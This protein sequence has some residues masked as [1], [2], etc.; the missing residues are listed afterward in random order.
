MTPSRHIRPLSSLLALFLLLAL[1]L[2]SSPAS[3]QIPDALLRSCPSVGN[4]G[5]P[6][7]LCTYGTAA[8]PHR[9][10]GDVLQ[11]HE[12]V[13]YPFDPPAFFRIGDSNLS[14]SMRSATVTFFYRVDTNNGQILETEFSGQ[15][16]FPNGAVG[17]KPEFSIRILDSNGASIDTVCLE[18]VY[19]G[20][21][22]PLWTSR[23]SSIIN[24]SLSRFLCFDLRPLHGRTVQIRFNSTCPSPYM[25]N[26][27]AKFSL[28]CINI[29]DIIHIYNCATARSSVAPRGFR[30][31]WSLSSDT[32]TILT[33][34][35]VFSDGGSRYLTELRCKLRFDSPTHQNT[36][37]VKNLYYTPYPA[38]EQAGY[39]FHRAPF[40][41]DT[42]GLLTS[43]TCLIQFRLRD[44]TMIRVL[45][46]TG[47]HYIHNSPLFQTQYRL[48]S[49]CDTLLLP[50]TTTRF[51]LPAG[52]HILYRDITT[53]T[54]TFTYSYNLQIDTFPCAYMDDLIR[55]CPETIDTCSIRYLCYTYGYH[56]H[57]NIIDS[58]PSGGWRQRSVNYFYPTYFYPY[59]HI[60]P[61]YGIYSYHH[62]HRNIDSPGP[63]SNTLGQ[64]STAPW[65]FQSS[66]LLGYETSDIRSNNQ[67]LFFRYHAD[68][69]QSSLLML[70]Y[71]LVM[72]HLA[73]DPTEFY[74]NTPWYQWLNSHGGVPLDSL[75]S[76][77]SKIRPRFLFHLLDSLGAE[78]SPE[79]YTLDI[80]VDTS[81]QWNIGKD[82]TF[83]WKDWTSFGIGLQRLHGRTFTVHI[84][85]DYTYSVFRFFDNPYWLYTSR[86]INYAYLHFQCLPGSIHA[87]HCRDT[88]HYT[89]PL[90]FNYQWFPDRHPDSI[91]ATSQTFVTTSD[92]IFY[93]RLTDHRDTT[94]TLILPAIPSPPQHPVA[95]LSLDTLQILD[96]CTYLLRLNNRSVIAT[97]HRPDSITTVP[98]NDIQCWLD[99]TLLIYPDTS[100]S[101]LKSSFYASPGQHTLT[102]VA[103]ITGTSCTDTLRRPLLLQD[104]CHCYDTIFDTIVQNQL[105]YQWHGITFTLDSFT[106][107]TQASHSQNSPNSPLSL[108]TSLFIPGTRPQCDSLISYHLTLYLNT[109]DSAILVLCPAAIPYHINDTLLLSS[110][111][112]FTLRG[113]HGQDSLVSY[114][115][116][117]L[118][119][120]DT[121]IVD[122]ILENQLPWFYFD[123]LFSDSVTNHPFHL[124]NEAGCDSTLYY[125]LYVFYD[126]D[127]CDTSLTFPTLVTPNADGVND[128]FV[129]G[130]L[131]E[132]NCFRF[133]DLLVYDRTGRLVYHGHNIASPSDW[134]DPAA[135]RA[136]D[137]TYFYIFR[138]HGVTIHTMHQGL[139]EILR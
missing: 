22:S 76:V 15:M 129:I 111:T 110:D 79:L 90:G 8:N 69:L 83:R 12:F 36:C 136:P 82:S 27:L 17:P 35:Q 57:I 51:N 108:D 127:H 24:L 92:S 105:P 19:S 45:D 135:Q 31:E 42:I 26:C 54:C 11:F 66:F 41:W 33:T 71:A 96:D 88:N 94:M 131:L 132:N 18:A 80:V 109:S 126:G 73:E 78:I 121:S 3:A 77:Q 37:F 97:E 124:F 14:D 74:S 84:D 29:A 13:P 128:L 91:V 99:D 138:A 6:R 32:N 30:Y 16:N 116:I 47:T 65:G 95:N 104:L 38:W 70:R 93:C 87:V 103:T 85:I 101:S 107:G 62:H 61:E 115:V 5:S 64:L 130:G 119:D 118:H 10:T 53:P 139:L 75:Y 120:S 100:S 48:I 21:N 58:L 7:V 63:D 72:Q 89:A 49:H 122:S 117:L 134:W 50:D 98:C 2:P 114:R 34:D 59:D 1:L 102:L 55:S 67:N 123:T 25:S 68:T 23:G 133:N 46:T 112:L 28:R 137:G 44:S 113:T 43:D 125:T 39:S 86:A 52:T 40:H 106:S 20:D 56:S 4:I 60:Y 9:D 81:P